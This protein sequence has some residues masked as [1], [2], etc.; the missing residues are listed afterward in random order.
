METANYGVRAR[1]R[2][3]YINAGR[4]L[5]K[6]ASM[7]PTRVINTSSVGIR[8]NRKTKPRCGRELGVVL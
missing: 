7:K 6:S 2:V 3:R 5:V 8:K 4:T 1:R